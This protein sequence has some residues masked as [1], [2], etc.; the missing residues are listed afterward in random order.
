MREW[1][2]LTDKKLEN[3]GERLYS[4]KN[5]PRVVLQVTGGICRGKS[6]SFE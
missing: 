5:D 4:T 2:P 1:Q 3:R 6:T